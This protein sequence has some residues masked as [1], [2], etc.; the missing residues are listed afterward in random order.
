MHPA[1]Q[2]LLSLCALAV[3][4]VLVPAI[5]AMRRSAQQAERILAILEEELRPLSGEIRALTEDLRALVKEANQDLERIGAVADRVH[6]I[7]NGF[8]RVVVALGGLTRAGQVV[9]VA[10]GLKR[11]I[12]VFVHRM[13]KGQGDDHE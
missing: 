1:A 5:V 13:R 4:I 11:G 12:D 7:A 3:T 6:D 9:G 10:A 2:I 8:A